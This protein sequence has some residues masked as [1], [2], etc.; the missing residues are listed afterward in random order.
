MKFIYGHVRS[1][2]KFSVCVEYTV[3]Y[4][5][6]FDFR[7]EFQNIEEN[8]RIVLHGSEL[9]RFNS[10]VDWTCIEH[11]PTEMFWSIIHSRRINRTDYFC[12]YIELFR[13]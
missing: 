12:N 10:I 8:K 6:E 11:S 7:M 1:S 2:L 5:H 3:N 4:M 9:S 13:S